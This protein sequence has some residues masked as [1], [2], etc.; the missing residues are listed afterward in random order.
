MIA[1][2]YALRRRKHNDSADEI[3][4]LRAENALLHGYIATAD[5][6][7]HEHGWESL[8]LLEARRAIAGVVER[9]LR[10]MTEDG[11]SLYDETGPLPLTDTEMDEYS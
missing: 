3:E 6:Y 1:D 8:V 7:F 10:R 2:L 11:A 5:A 9:H 4:R